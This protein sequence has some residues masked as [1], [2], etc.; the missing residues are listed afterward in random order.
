MDTLL[1]RASTCFGFLI[2]L[3][4]TACGGCGSPSPEG[5]TTSATVGP[6][7]GVVQAP[8]GVRLDIPAGALDKMTVITIAPS[9]AILAG[10]VGAAAEIGPAGTS[11]SKPVTLTLPYD[12][13]LLGSASATAIRLA[14]LDGAVVQPQPWAVVNP[15]DHSV[16]S[17]I[18]HLSPWA[19]VLVPQ[20]GGA[21]CKWT[22][23]DLACAQ[24]CCTGEFCATE[25]GAACFGGTDIITLTKCYA[26]CVGSPQAVNF[27]SGCL[28][29][30]CV[31]Q[32]GATVGP[33]GT[34]VLSA[35]TQFKPIMACAAE[36]FKSSSRDQIS[37][38]TSAELPTG[39]ACC[40]GGL[41]P[42]NDSCV[43]MRSDTKNCGKCGVACGGAQVCQGSA[44]ACVNPQ[45]TACG[46][47]CIDTS[48]DSK[49]C[50]RCGVACAD[51]VRC[52]YG[53]CDIKAP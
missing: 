10:A 27:G 39:P 23:S 1:R 5:T 32:S 3:S 47:S 42:C 48:A 29:N 33:D 13:A 18:T 50:G 25:K 51:G 41:T 43:D 6:T 16:Q 2:T 21:N 38:C 36:C 44:C 46:G 20:I 22:P 14:S 28:K 40:P 37:L 49:N 45:L 53:S 30:C 12:P 19:A 26:P 35:T 52:Y 31:A 11:F 17:F 24:R 9:T 7:G 34:C 4:F 8:F 15:A